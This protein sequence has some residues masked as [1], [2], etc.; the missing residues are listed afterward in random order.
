MS[1]RCCPTNAWQAPR[2][3]HAT[4]LLFPLINHLIR[5]ITISSILTSQSPHVDA[6]P[7]QKQTPRPILAIHWCQPTLQKINLSKSLK[8]TDHISHHF[9]TPGFSPRPLARRLVVRFHRLSS[10]A[11]LEVSPV[12]GLQG[13]NEDDVRRAKDTWVKG[14]GGATGRRI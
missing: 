2:Y 3:L 6:K 9:P 8:N 11:A 12:D 5:K 14:V 4:W 1:E 10:R 7:N 13:K